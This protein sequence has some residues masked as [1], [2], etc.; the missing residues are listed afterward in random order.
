MNLKNI[1][2]YLLEKATYHQVISMAGLYFAMDKV[3][4]IETY[5]V[6]KFN[7]IWADAIANIPFY[8]EWRKKHNLP[9]KISSLKELMAWPVLTKLELTEDPG[10]DVS[11]LSSRWPYNHFRV[12]RHSA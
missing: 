11:Q 6:E 4:S 9:A 12:Y 8:T 3:S 10:K 2:S 1:V 7:E 5:Q